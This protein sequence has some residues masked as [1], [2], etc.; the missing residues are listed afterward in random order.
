MSERGLRKVRTGRVTSARM[1]KT[2]VVTVDR[3][4]QHPLYGK[5]VKKR[6]KLYAHDEENRCTEGDIVRVMETR[7]LSR[8]KSWRVVE[9]IKKATD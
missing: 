9:I 8:T 1:E 2:V 4:V 6:S 5:T 7:P 3:L